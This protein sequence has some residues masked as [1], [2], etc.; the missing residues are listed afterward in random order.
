MRILGEGEGA[1]SAR[2]L[3]PQP[4]T[5]TLGFLYSV[6][7]TEQNLVLYPTLYTHRNGMGILSFNAS[8]ADTRLD[9]HTSPNTACDRISRKKQTS[10]GGE[11][12]GQKCR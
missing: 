9:Q 5:H 10:R 7:G 4:H 3:V 2:S 8:K 11:A 6:G 1:R 12:R